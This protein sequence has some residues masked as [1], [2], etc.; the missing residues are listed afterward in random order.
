LS[1][2]HTGSHSKIAA[3]HKHY[4]T[5]VLTAAFVINRLKPCDSG[6]VQIQIRCALRRDILPP[7]FF[8]FSFFPPTHSFSAHILSTSWVTTKLSSVATMPL[9]RVRK[10]RHWHQVT[11]T[12]KSK[13]RIMVR[14]NPVATTIPTHPSSISRSVSD[15]FRT[16][17]P[18]GILTH[19]GSSPK[20]IW[21][22]S[23]PLQ[24]SPEKFHATG[25]SATR[26]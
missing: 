6:F 2:C 18:V 10:P 8:Y 20:Y 4:T 23:Y 15:M 13:I 19:S 16:L 17:H 1:H 25:A 9:I 11:I 14:P 21:T 7:Y 12:G 24:N 5:N 22:D 26:L 3:C